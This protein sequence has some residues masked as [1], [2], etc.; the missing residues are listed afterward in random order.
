MVCKELILKMIQ[1]LDSQIKAYTIHRINKQ[2]A[3]PQRVRRHAFVK[4][5]A[6]L[7]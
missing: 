4:N 7:P 6:S 5:D 3:Q 2:R 1:S